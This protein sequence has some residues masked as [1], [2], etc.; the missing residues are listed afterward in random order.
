MQLKLSQ[1]NK[2][3]NYGKKESLENKKIKE[4]NK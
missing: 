3:L 2:L 1:L 4:N